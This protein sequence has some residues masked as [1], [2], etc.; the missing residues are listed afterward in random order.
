MSIYHYPLETSRKIEN[1]RQ[2]GSE[3]MRME[4]TRRCYTL[5]NRTE[6]TPFFNLLLD[7]LMVV[8]LLLTLRPQCDGNATQKRRDRDDKKQRAEAKLESHDRFI[9]QSKH[10]EQG[11]CALDAELMK[12]AGNRAPASVPVYR[13]ELDG[14]SGG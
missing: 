5:R 9:D 6:A 7:P 3:L 8:R 2:I 13:T 14:P 10:S 11:C 1:Q 12:T 4:S